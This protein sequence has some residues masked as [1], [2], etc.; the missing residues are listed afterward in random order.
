MDE[1]T[2][3]VTYDFDAVAAWLAAE[4][5]A[6]HAWGAFGAETAAPRLLV[7][8]CRSVARERT[9]SCGCV[10]VRVCSALLKMD[11]SG[12]ARLCLVTG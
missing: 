1:T 6:Y 4:M 10:Q 9:R 12:E 7:G 3:C 11:D 2:V 5:P 8:R